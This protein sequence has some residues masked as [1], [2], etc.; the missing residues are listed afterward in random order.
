METRGLKTNVMK[1]DILYD[2]RSTVSNRYYDSK[3]SANSK[4]VEVV[5]PT[6]EVH[7]LGEYKRMKA[8]VSETVVQRGCDIMKV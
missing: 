7:S 6:V 8:V 1:T 2:S 3:S 5:R 4:Q